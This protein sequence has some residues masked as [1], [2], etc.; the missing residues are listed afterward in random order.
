MKT[1]SIVLCFLFLLAAPRLAD[2]CSCAGGY[3]VCRAYADADAILIGSVQR[4]ENLEAKPGDV[5]S[6][7]DAGQLA[8][9]QVEQIFKGR[10]ETES[11]RLKV[12][13]DLEGLK[14]IFPFTY[15]EKAKEE[16]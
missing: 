6:D 9:I 7:E 11:L 8:H 3:T 14:L 13:A 12:T 1:S 2:A 10:V 15:C 4:V 16:K 5:R